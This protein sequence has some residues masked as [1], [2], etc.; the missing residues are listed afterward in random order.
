MDK[1]TIAKIWSADRRKEYLMD[2][3]GFSKPR[4]K[5]TKNKNKYTRKTKHKFKDRH[6]NNHKF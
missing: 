3:P 2:N 4:V 5:K 1:E 6:E